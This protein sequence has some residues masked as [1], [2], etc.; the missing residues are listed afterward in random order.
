MVLVTRT[1]ESLS[2]VRTKEDGVRT[3]EKEEGQ[4][5]CSAGKN[6]IFSDNGV[7]CEDV[8]TPGVDVRQDPLQLLLQKFKPVSNMRKHMRIKHILK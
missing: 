8:E 5:E 1:K 2:L 4:P 7:R 6:P 3:K